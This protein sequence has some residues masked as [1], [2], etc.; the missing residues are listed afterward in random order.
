MLT[1]SKPSVIDSLDQLRA[2]DFESL[3]PRR[4]P[5]KAL[6]CSPDHFCVIDVK[7]PYMEGNA[8]AVDLAKARQQWETLKATFEAL[9]YPVEVIPGAEGC[10]DMVFSANQTLPGLDE[11]D[12]PFVLLS[13]M[14]HP[15]RQQEVP[16]FRAWF[17]ARGYRIHELP[18]VDMLLEGQG[19]ALWHPEKKLLWGGY[20]HRTDRSTYDVVA[21]MLRVPVVALRL[22]SDTFYHL[23]TCLSLINST[24]AMA[25]L[26]AFDAEGTAMLRAAFPHLIEIPTQEA[27]ECFAGNA[28]A[29][30]GRHVVMHPGAVETMARL[31]AIGLEPVEVDTS[32][33]MKSGGSVFCMKVMIY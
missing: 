23:D 26:D 17:E 9:G 3:P 6:M 10:E 19:D 14:R 22:V 16:H 11:D 21:D 25:V 33:Y 20:G 13:N 1:T 30:G 31:R 32:E 5:D 12:K 15:S 27:V 29:L 18:R 2:L 7:N 24:T 4:E 8:G 28:L